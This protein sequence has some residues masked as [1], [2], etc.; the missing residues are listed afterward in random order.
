[1]INRDGK[2]II[3][4]EFWIDFALPKYQKKQEEIKV[5]S[6]SMVTYRVSE[7]RAMVVSGG[8]GQDEN[9]FLQDGRVVSNN[10]SS[11]YVQHKQRDID[12]MVKVMERNDIKTI[13]KV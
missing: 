9:E 1:M 13:K 3:L 10:F 2:L 7:S 6:D 12:E 8:D 4:D 11:F 5:D